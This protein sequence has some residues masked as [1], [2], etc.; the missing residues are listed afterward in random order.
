MSNASEKVAEIY[1]FLDRSML[2]HSNITSTDIIEFIECQWSIM[3]E[4]KYKIHNANIIIARMVNEYIK[5]KDIENVKRWLTI[6]D[7]HVNRKI[8]EDYIVNYY[9]GECLYACGAEDDA[10]N[11]FQ[12]SY[13]ENK[14]YIFTR[15]RACMEFFN[16]HL[17]EPKILSEPEYEDDRVCEP[18]VLSSWVSFFGD[19]AEQLYYSLGGDDPT[20]CMS[21]CHKTG[22]QYIIDHQSEILASILTELIKNYPELQEQYD[23]DDEEKELYMPDVGTQEDFSKLLSPLAI[24]ILSVH[25]NGQPYI[26][27]EFSCSWDIEHYFGVMMLYDRV[28]K[29]GGADTSFL[30]WIAEEDLEKTVTVD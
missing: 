28:V 20:S 9:R 27:F 3:D 30:T 17:D 12:R 16:R 4:E 14:E 21:E 11:Y 10:L 22:L 26:G 6:G 13:D 2:K 8:N 15:N 19:E 24:H 29:L 5:L 18:I 1:G 25:N 7:N 23:Y